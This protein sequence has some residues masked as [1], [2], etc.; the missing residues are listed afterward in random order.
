MMDE[1]K[2][3]M[4]APRVTPQEGVSASTDTPVDCVHTYASALA[5]VGVLSAQSVFYRCFNPPNNRSAFIGGH[6]WFGF[7]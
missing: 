7:C 4:K 3:R 5:Y 1:K 6:L 2:P